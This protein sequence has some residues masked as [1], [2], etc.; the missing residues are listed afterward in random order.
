MV[1]VGRTEVVVGLTEV[2]VGRTEVV[3]V[4]DRTEVVVVVGRTE[5]VVVV[6]RT[7]VVVLRTVV[8]GAANVVASAPTF[9]D[10][11]VLVNAHTAYKYLVEGFSPLS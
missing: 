9:V 8:V 11:P 4:V 10:L 2:V 6:G 7:E 1:V 5:V 3:V